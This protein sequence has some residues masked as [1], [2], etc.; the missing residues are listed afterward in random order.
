MSNIAIH[1]GHSPGLVLRKAMIRIVNHSD[2]ILTVNDRIKSKN[3]K[4][5]TKHF[6]SFY[7]IVLEVISNYRTEQ[8]KM[9]R[10]IRKPQSAY[11][12]TKPQ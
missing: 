9:S 8:L 2:L 11:A 3:A 6:W 7:I 12:K 10:C 4:K 1:D 5:Q